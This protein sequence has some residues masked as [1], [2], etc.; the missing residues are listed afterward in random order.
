M[1]PEFKKRDADLPYSPDSRMK[2][3]GKGPENTD[4]GS[5]ELKTGH[6]L[7]KSRVFTGTTRLPGDKI[8]KQKAAFISRLCLYKETKVREITV[9]KNDAD[10]RID[11]FLLKTLHNMPQSLLYKLLR[12]KRIKLNGKK[13]QP[14][15][16]LAYNDIIELYI[17]DEF[18]DDAGK[19]DKAKKLDRNSLNLKDSEIVYEDENIILIDKPQGELVHSE[20]PG[21]KKG[22]ASEI[23]LV[24]RL[25]GYLYKKG[26]YDPNTQ[27]SFAPALCNRLDRNTCGIVIA[28]K[29]AKVLAILNQK[30][31]DRELE[32]KYLCVVYG[33]PKEKHKLM[34]DYL[35]KDKNSN[36][37]FIFPTP[38]QA[39]KV[40]KIKYDDDIKTV[41][42]EYTVKKVYSDKALLEVKLITGRTHQIRAHLAY[43][44]HPIVGDGKYGINHKTKTGKQYQMLCSHY[45]KFDF[46]TDAGIL[47]YLDGKEFFSSYNM[48][49]TK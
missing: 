29:N 26:E 4:V 2:Q 14:N 24:D 27:N 12:T 40:C 33:I 17:S 5:T 49:S 34:K 37:V 11:K 36:K 9:N 18:F 46:K 1:E 38:E 20:M 42:T 47:S 6:H 21:E 35:Y 22:E 28:A 7:A 43:I 44:G 32:K 15:T 16:I 48:E 23:C 45:L 3:A 41:I 39:K 30:I 19:S 8:K 10:K 25:C 13:A 31:K